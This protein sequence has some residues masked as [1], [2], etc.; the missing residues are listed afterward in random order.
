MLGRE[1]GA[2]YLNPTNGVI[3]TEEQ[4]LEYQKLDSN[5]KMGDLIYVDSNDDGSI[6]SEDRVYSGSGLPDYELG[7]N[8]SLEYK[9]FDFSMNWYA[10]VG[11]ENYE[12]VQGCPHIVTKHIPT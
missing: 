4:L 7:V 10:A 2:F 1:A 3:K 5:A 9:K 11:G 12:R 8:M 6:S